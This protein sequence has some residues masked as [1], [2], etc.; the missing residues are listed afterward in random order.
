MAHPHRRWLDLDEAGFAQFLEAYP[1][2]LAIHPPLPQR[3]RFREWRDE[4]LGQWPEN[5]I[6]KPCQ[7]GRCIGYQVRGDFGS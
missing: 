1:R 2:P 6:A 3:V 5:V 4:T 7:R